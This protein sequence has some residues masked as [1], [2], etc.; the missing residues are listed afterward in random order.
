MWNKC[1]HEG[2]WKMFW[3]WVTS[4]KS[5]IINTKLTSLY[6]HYHIKIK[7]V[8]W[9]DVILTQLT[10]THTVSLFIFHDTLVVT[11]WFKSEITSDSHNAASFLNFLLPPSSYLSFFVFLSLSV[12]FFC[13]KIRFMDSHLWS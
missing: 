1:R 4:K 7:T 9:C 10:H 12:S 13:Y 11:H 3:T 5:R 2:K 8:M 6:V